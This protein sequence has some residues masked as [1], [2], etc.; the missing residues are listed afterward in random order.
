MTPTA[1]KN[2][3]IVV[4]LLAGGTSLALI[5]FLT[6]Q[7]VIVRHALVPGSSTTAQH[8]TRADQLV[9]EIGQAGAS[10]T[11]ASPVAT[12]QEAQPTPI[13]STD[14]TQTGS[15]ENSVSST[16]AIPPCDKPDGLGLSRI[17]QIDPTGGPRFGL[18]QHPEGYDFLRDK[19][20]VLT[21]DDGPR[22]SSTEAVVKALA[23]ECLKA[24]FFEVGQMASWHPEVTKQ[25]IDAGMTVG[26]HTWSHKD[27]ARIPPEKA[28]QE[29][30]MA[31]SAVNAAAGGKIAPFF[32]FPYLA[33]P[34]RIFSYLAERNIAIF[35][36]DID[37]RDY[38]MHKPQLVVD[39][40]MSQ[41]EKR[42]R[43]IVL[44]HDIHSNTAEALPELLRQL[45]VA[46]FKVVH[47]VPKE[48]LT[49][50]AKY[51]ELLDHRKNVSSNTQPVSVS[52]HDA[53]T[54]H[55]IYMYVPPQG[56]K[57]APTTSTTGAH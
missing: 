38:T 6:R 21:F 33:Q 24:T 18:I 31:N 37:S 9:S 23:D 8:S 10:G 41:L 51:D 19:E 57:G 27:L 17:V 11:V 14:P 36:G 12:V 56:R 13:P 7:Q 55:S 39:S 25:V 46:G 43:G 34:P 44:M 30:E 50:I 22:P 28:E 40:V 52:G 35:S 45:K 53:G 16:S 2:L 20:V 49:T 54:H 4:A 29:I 1:L 15:A 48:Q 42:G 47:M 26:T 3:T 5:G 32:R